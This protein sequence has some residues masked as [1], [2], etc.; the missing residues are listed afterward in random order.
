[1]HLSHKRIS[2]NLFRHPSRVDLQFI[3]ILLATVVSMVFHPPVSMLPSSA[4]ACNKTSA[5][6]WKINFAI[7]A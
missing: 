5:L 1:M 7:S 2:S 4:A 3:E 6:Y